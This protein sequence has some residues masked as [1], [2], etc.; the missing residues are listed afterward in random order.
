MHE[1]ALHW[2]SLTDRLPPPVKDEEIDRAWLAAAAQI[3]GKIIVLDDDPTGVQTVHAVPVYTSW[4]TD[5]LRRVMRETAKVVYILTNSR[6][7][8][9]SETICLH[10]RLAASLQLIAR[11]ENQGMLL[12]SRSDSTLRGHYPAETHALY[13]VLAKDAAVDGEIIAP[14]F[15]EGGRFTIG[16]VHYVREGEMLVPAGR[17]EFARDPTFGYE[18]SDLK[19]WI[20]EKTGGAFPAARVLAIPLEMLRRREI[21]AIADRLMSVTGFNKVVLNAVAY[22]DLKVFT[23]ALAEALARGKR[24]LFRTAAS[25]VQV[26]GGIKPKPLLDRT[27]LYGT[28]VSGGPGL[29][30]AG[31]YVQKTTAQLTRLRD[32][33]G[34]AWVEWEA[35]AAR[36]TRGLAA[37]ADRV[38]SEVESALAFG[39]DVCVYTSRD[40][41][42]QEKSAVSERNLIFSTRVSDGLVRVVQGL[43]TRPGFLVVKGGITSS[44]IGVKGLGVRR[45]MVMGQIR[46]GV[47]VWELDPESRFPGL[48][49]IIFPGNVGTD[50]TLKDVVEVLRG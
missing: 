50:E 45:A 12:I 5:A 7:L 11:E 48:P 38:V 39:M 32:L 36:T 27:T 26:M 9:K 37:E 47:P 44:D 23:I 18:S 15:P 21:P 30:V 8:T 4:D 6:A 25:F 31:S 3:E 40:Y 14:C 17:T 1:K 24:F 29:I 22:S 42:R 49:Y 35:A 10:G 2:Q 41:L 16:D 46:P 33:P 19:E 20:A 43:R 34:M 13:E 28:G